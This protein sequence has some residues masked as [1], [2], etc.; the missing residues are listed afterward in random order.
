MNEANDQFDDP[1]LKA[2][3]KGVYGAESAP[4][5]LRE[6]VMA[7]AATAGARGGHSAA[8]YV[9]R[10]AAVLLVVIGT[11]AVV[12]YDRLNPAIARETMTALVQDHQ[13]SAQGRVKVQNVAWATAGENLASEVQ[14]TVW[15]ADLL[16]EGWTFE[17]A[18]VCRING[19]QVAHLLF[20]MGGKHLSVYSLPRSACPKAKR[21]GTC[22]VKVDDRHVLVGVVDE[23]GVFCLVGHCPKGGLKVAD[24]QK[25]FDKH[26]GERVGCGTRKAATKEVEHH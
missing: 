6:R 24:V 13:E 10:V 16:C 17:G 9:W 25:L 2:A 21:A 3:L 26:Q 23:Q 20:S 14:N 11:L 1:S 7:L 5:R 22:A 19:Q 15:A 12:L 8:W 18:K 4:Q